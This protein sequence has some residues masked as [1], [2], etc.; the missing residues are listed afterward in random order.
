M[1]GNDIVDL[2][3]ARKTSGWNRKGFLKKVFTKDEIEAIRG[4][5]DPF[6]MVWR[7]WSMKESAYKVYVQQGAERFFNPQRLECR[8]IKSEKGQVSL[9]GERINTHTRIHRQYI[10]TSAITTLKTLA[11]DHIFYISHPNY[12]AQSSLTHNRI[13]DCLSTALNLFKS[14]LEIRK[15]VFGIPE[16]LYMG[17]ILP[18]AISMTHHGHYG[19][20]SWQEV[21]SLGGTTKSVLL[22]YCQSP[23]GKTTGISP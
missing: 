14:R 6:E 12:S 17:H 19:A 10:F 4:S 18:I 13:L 21:Q 2:N 22:E 7:L 9:G 20:C 8:M 15:T 5:K 3:I 1:V 23:S 16:V 11:K